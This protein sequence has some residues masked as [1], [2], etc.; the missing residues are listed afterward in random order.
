MMRVNFGRKC[1]QVI[2]SPAVHQELVVPNGWSASLTRDHVGMR[3]HH[4]YH[5]GK[6]LIPCRVHEC[7]CTLGNLANGGKLVPIYAHITEIL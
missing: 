5:C 7:S 1:P 3:T 6:L 2:S 4:E